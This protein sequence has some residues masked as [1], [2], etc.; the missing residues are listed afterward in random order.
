MTASQRHTGGDLRFETQVIQNEHAEDTEI[1]LALRLT[2][3]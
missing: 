2:V 1:Y 3:I